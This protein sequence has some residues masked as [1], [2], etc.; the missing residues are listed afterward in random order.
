MVLLMRGISGSGKTTEAQRWARTVPGSVVVSTDD[1]MFAGGRPFNPGLLQ[2][3]HEQCQKDF[4]QALLDKAPLVIVDN[5]NTKF[6]SMVP[7]VEIIERH[8]YDFTVMQLHIDPKTALQRTTHAVPLETLERM[9]KRMWFERLPPSWTV[10][11]TGKPWR[12]ND[13]GPQMIG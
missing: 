10:Y 7:Y 1:Y 4:E 9:G 2:H 6:S 3:S 13:I 11:S 12:P 5:T 8:R